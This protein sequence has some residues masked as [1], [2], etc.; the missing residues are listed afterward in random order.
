LV[1]TLIGHRERK[2]ENRERKMFYPR[3]ER[4]FLQV[5][6]PEHFSIRGG[7]E[8]FVPVVHHFFITFLFAYTLIGHRERKKEK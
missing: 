6:I 4:R 2:K 1:Y 7:R 3:C 8:S 5:L